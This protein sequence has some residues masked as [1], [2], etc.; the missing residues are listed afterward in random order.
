MKLTQEILEQANV[1]IDNAFPYT[2]MKRVSVNGKRLY[3]VAGGEK[4]PS[5]TTILSATKDMTAIWEWQKRIGVEKAREITTEAAN[6]GTLMHASV[7]KHSLR[8]DR[9][10]GTN[11]IH[12]KAHK[13][14]NVI[15]NNAF[16]DISKVYGTEVNLY[17]PKLYAG[18]TDMIC[19]HKGTIQIADFK[20]S[21]KLKKR[22]Y[23]EDYFLQLTAY[24]LAH[25]ELYGTKIRN[26]TIFICTQNFEFQRFELDNFADWE[27]RW[28]HKLEEYYTK[29]DK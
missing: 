9:T 25:N 24:A 14:A 1:T 26:G 22:E 18:T 16:V 13:M 11:F 8:K 7:E 15:I 17:F 29:L 27:D 20:Q 23:I 5:V 4:L 10:P 6:I 21:R 2:E 19:E 28:F 3:E 12:Q